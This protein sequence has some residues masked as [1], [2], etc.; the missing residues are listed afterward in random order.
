MPGLMVLLLL[1]LPPPPNTYSFDQLL[2]ACE[3]SF[4]STL[5]LH[6]QTPS[7]GLLHRLLIVSNPALSLQSLLPPSS[8]GQSICHSL[9]AISGE[10]LIKP[11]QKCVQ[12]L[13][14]KFATTTIPRQEG[15]KPAPETPINGQKPFNF[16]SAVTR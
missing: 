6:P 16:T 5:F 11:G 15:Q 7:P 8:I 13:Y 1:L 4:Y 12:N 10:R 9:R 2:M 3:R 14:L